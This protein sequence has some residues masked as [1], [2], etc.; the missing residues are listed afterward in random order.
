MKTKTIPAYVLILAVLLFLVSGCKKQPFMA[1]EDAVITLTAEFL[2]I[3]LGANVRIFIIG[4]NSDGSL[5]WDGTRVDLTIENGSLDVSTVELTDGK[6]TVTATANSS[7][8]EMKIS[9]RSGNVVAETLI[10]NVGQVTEV[11]QIVVNLNPPV[12]P[13]DGGQIEIT[14][15]IYDSYMDPIPGIAVALESDTGTLASKGSALT[16]D[17]S[18][19]VTDYLETTQAGTVTIYCSDKTK[20]VDITLEEEPDANLPPV[21]EF[22]FSPVEPI[23]GDEVYFNASESYDEDGSIRRYVWDFGDGNSGSGKKTVHIFDLENLSYQTYMVTLTVFDDDDASDSVSYEVT[24][25][26]KTG[27]TGKKRR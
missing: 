5:L 14:V 8:G 17:N 26:Q 6:A 27:R 11:H 24:V 7:R 21:A 23:A 16:T 22:T 9:A 18:G 1:G 19:T 20:T 12:L 4:Y 15:K 3:A 10:I 25:R 2:D 13:F